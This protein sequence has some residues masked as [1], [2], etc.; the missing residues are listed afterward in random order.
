MGSD[1]GDEKRVTL[2]TIWVELGAAAGLEVCKRFL[3]ASP[4]TVE[5]SVVI[6]VERVPAEGDARGDRDRVAS[7]ARRC[8]PL[9]S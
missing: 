9:A 8:K 3:D 7:D 1:P 2:S 5:R 4:L 6:A